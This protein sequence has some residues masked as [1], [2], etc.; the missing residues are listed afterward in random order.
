MLIIHNISAMS[1]RSLLILWFHAKSGVQSIF[2]VLGV[3]QT[4]K[5]VHQF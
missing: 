4:L 2:S 3:R 5:N 1:I